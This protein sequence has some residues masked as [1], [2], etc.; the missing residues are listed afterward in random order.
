MYSE[1]DPFDYQVLNLT[2]KFYT[3]Y[4]DPPYKEIVRKNNR[5]YSCLLVQ[6][7]YGYFICIPYRSHINHKYA[8]KFKNSIRSKRTKSGLDY[9]KIV[10]IRKSEYIGT[11]DAM[12]DKDEF[13]ETRDHIEYIKNDAQRYID[14]YVNSVLG[15]SEKYDKK[16]FERVYKYSTLHY[17]H[18]ELEIIRSNRDIAN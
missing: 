9:S 16:E 1:E 3:D 6:S 12:V 18:N 4:P 7:R 5:P 11:I 17:F 13:N 14:N 2:D 15:K 8:F 10:I